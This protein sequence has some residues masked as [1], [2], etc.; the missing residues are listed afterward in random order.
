M[1]KDVIEELARLLEGAKLYSFVTRIWVFRG[2]FPVVD[3]EYRDLKFSVDFVISSDHVVSVDVVRRQS[4]YRENVTVNNDVK[5]RIA[6]DVTLVRAVDLLQSRVQ[7]IIAAVDGA[8]SSNKKYAQNS[9]ASINRLTKTSGAQKRV[10][11]LTLPF[12]MNIGGNLQGYALVEIL[13]QM[14]HLPILI[15]RRGVSKN[16]ENDESAFEQD[17]KIPLV[18]NTIAM[19]PPSNRAFVEKYIA[20][21]SR[22]FSSTM[23]LKRNVDRYE[24]DAVIVGS[25]Q[26]WR[27]RYTKG[28]LQDFFLEFIGDENKKTK[29]IS[30]AASF[31]S[32]KWE[33]DA[34]QTKIAASLIKRFD[35]I[36]VREDSA[37]ELCRSNL[38]V[39]AEHVLDPTMLLPV[40][41]YTSLL[42]P[43]TNFTKI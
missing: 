33:Y 36:S 38:G 5:E 4:D 11:V 7:D 32:P 41:H 42:A 34:D 25:D 40:E 39:E 27:P 24:F 9:I 29:K 16:I 43:N 3:F 6:Q 37:V 26:V 22:Q 23:Q 8:A 19:S 13:R 35:A 15:N 2:M 1:F 14:G 31:G 20:T 30:Y 17:A 21:I 18:S 28:M 10:G 12:N